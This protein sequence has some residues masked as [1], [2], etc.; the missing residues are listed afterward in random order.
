MCYI[1]CALQKMASCLFW[2]ATSVETCTRE[3]E[4][5][6]SSQVW[7]EHSSMLSITK[8]QNPNP[9]SKNLNQSHLPVTLHGLTVPHAG[10]PSRDAD[11]SVLRSLITF[12][13]YTWTC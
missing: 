5:V 1:A 2:I 9:Q 13:W 10:N 7:T 12:I 8:Q 3:C 6:M 11:T 4:H